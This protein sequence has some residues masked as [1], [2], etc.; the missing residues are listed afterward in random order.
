MLDII[1]QFELQKFNTLAVPVNAKYYTEAASLDAL[2]EALAWVRQHKLPLMVLGGGSNII[3]KDHFPGLVLHIKISGV[4]VVKETAQHVWVKAGAGEN[5]HGFVQTCLSRNFWGLENL[6][7]IPGN[8]GAAPIQNIGAYGIEL[9]DVFDELEAVSRSSGQT[10]IFCL[11]DCQFG[12]RDSIFKNQLLDQFIIT[13]VTVK[14]NKQPA[15]HL[16]YPALKQAAAQIEESL[17]PQKVS[18]LVCQIRRSKLPEPQSLPNAGSFF[19]N[20]VVS[21]DC[22]DQ[23]VR[24]YKSMPAYPQSD[25]QIKLAAGWMIDQAGWRGFRDEGVAVHN[26][27]ALV[28]VNP[29][30]C[31]GEKILQLAE[32]I[33]QS[34]TQRFGVSLELEPRVYP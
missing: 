10:E 34:V 13:S 12:Y 30:H 9:C 21:Q 26:E 1:P 27:Q 19:K 18:E 7:L 4:E 20:P 23:L 25:N 3:L 15:L 32:K 24:Q 14:L 11:Q 16:E 31:S 6:S 22:Y 33:K 17:T 8:V 29:G 5:W 28:L 2:A